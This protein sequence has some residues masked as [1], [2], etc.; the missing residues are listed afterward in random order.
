MTKNDYKNYLKELY[1][2]Q[3]KEYQVFTKPIVNSKYELIGIRTPILK[4]EAKKISK[5]NYLDYLKY[6]EFSTYEEVLLYGLIVSNIKDYSLYKEYMNIYLDKCDS[7]AL[8]DGVV[9]NSKVIK[10]NLEDNLD[11]IDELIKTKKEFYVRT[12]YI[13]LK[14]FYIDGIHNKDIYK[15]IDKNKTD[16][17]YV[18]MAIAWLLCDLFIKD[19]DNALDYVKNSNLSSTIINMTVRKCLDSFRLTDNQ[20]E[21]IRK[22]KVSN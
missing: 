5:S 14:A 4:D 16:K 6:N 13:M 11:Y 22:I 17:Y 21:E 20:K 2:K 15:Y 19:Y 7:W 3:D 10:K 12:G 9:A 8:I 1:S 18:N